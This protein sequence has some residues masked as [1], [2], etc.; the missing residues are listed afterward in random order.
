MADHLV[1]PLLLCLPGSSSS[2]LSSQFASRHPHQLLTQPLYQQVTT[3]MAA[4]TKPPGEPAPV[5]V[6][7]RKGRAE[8]AVNAG[9]GSS[10]TSQR[11][12]V[13]HRYQ[14]VRIEDHLQHVLSNVILPGFKCTDRYRGILPFIK[15]HKMKYKPP[16]TR[17]DDT[18]GAGHTRSGFGNDNQPGV[19][20]GNISSHYTLVVHNC[21][22]QLLLRPSA[23]KKLFASPS[24]RPLHHNKAPSVFNSA[25]LSPLH[26][27]PVTAMPP[28]TH[29]AWPS[30][31]T[32]SSQMV[33]GTSDRTSTSGS[34]GTASSRSQQR[35]LRER[36]SNGVSAAR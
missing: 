2:R 13:Y 10:S 16:T 18:Y 6:V 9:N 20:G 25:F 23:G 29:S 36:K 21:R 30:T 33:H 12:A 28:L 27:P 1:L 3:L 31:S 35:R 15:F 11:S 14:Y 22:N 19:V 17:M 7:V 32:C 34:A 26:Y 8:V 5:R 24:K 4:L